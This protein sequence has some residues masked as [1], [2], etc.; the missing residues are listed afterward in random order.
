MMSWFDSA[1]TT[2]VAR[3]GRVWPLQAEE[4]RD[5]ERSFDWNA[6]KLDYKAIDREDKIVIALSMVIGFELYVLMRL[7]NIPAP[8]IYVLP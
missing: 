3:V 8:I 6:L 7:L 5:S 1:L 4:N 2:I